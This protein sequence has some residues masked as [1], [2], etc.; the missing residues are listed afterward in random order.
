VL[1]ISRTSHRLISLI[2]YLFRSTRLVI[3]FKNIYTL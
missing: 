2:Y 1:L 3:L